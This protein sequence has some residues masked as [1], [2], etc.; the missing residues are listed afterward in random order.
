MGHWLE[1]FVRESNRIEGIFDPPWAGIGAHKEFLSRSKINVAA[2]ERLVG[3][4]AA[5]HRLRDKYGL[6]VRVGNYIAPPGGPKIRLRLENLLLHMHENPPFTV[7]R[8]YE[9]LHPFTDGNGRSGR[10]LW[11]WHLQAFVP[12]EFERAKVLG[13]LHTFYYQALA[14]P[15]V[16]GL[17]L[18]PSA[19]PERN[20]IE[21]G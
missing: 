2:L 21:R 15:D 19:T 16:L 4:L 11:L 13:F 7:H 9:T 20:E 14:G 18:L 10:A 5:G 6:N 8:S 3:I 1:L 17:K 12:K